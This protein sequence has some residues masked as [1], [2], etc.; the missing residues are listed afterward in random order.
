MP[1]MLHTIVPRNG[2]L[3]YLLT[4][5]L[6]LILV[7]DA[8]I[9]ATKANKN[10]SITQKIDEYFISLSTIIPFGARPYRNPAAKPR[11]L[12]RK[13]NR[14]MR[15]TAKQRKLREE[16]GRKAQLQWRQVNR[17]LDIEQTI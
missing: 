4:S 3:R 5:T 9:V 1:A 7:I 8:I 16:L 15:R 12:R 6:S 13:W 2:F 14:R 17:W 11:A 10:Q